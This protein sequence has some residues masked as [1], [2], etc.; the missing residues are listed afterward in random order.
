MFED[1]GV[2]SREAGAKGVL[3]LHYTKMSKSIINAS[4]S[5]FHFDIHLFLFLNVCMHFYSCL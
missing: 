4:D 2:L 1:R 3:A 5:H